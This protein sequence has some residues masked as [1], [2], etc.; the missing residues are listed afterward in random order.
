MIF[1]IFRIYVLLIVLPIW[2]IKALYCAAWA[3]YASFVFDVRDFWR[4]GG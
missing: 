2:L 3:M 1:S 4:L